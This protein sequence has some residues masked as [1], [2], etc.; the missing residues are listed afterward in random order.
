M[1]HRLDAVLGRLTRSMAEGASLQSFGVG[2]IGLIV[3]PIDPNQAMSLMTV[4]GQNQSR[5]PPE[6]RL[7]RY[8]PPSKDIANPPHLVPFVPMAQRGLVTRLLN[9]SGALKIR[10]EH[11]ANERPRSAE[12]PAR[13]YIARIVNSEI[14]AA[15][16]D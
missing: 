4:T 6:T 16:T 9:P 3:R 15:D 11:L 8:P 5:R 12:A 13:Q 14:Y 7:P 1:T 2:G 10:H